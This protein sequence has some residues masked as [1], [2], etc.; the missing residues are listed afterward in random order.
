[1]QPPYGVEGPVIRRRRW[2]D[3]PPGRVR[4]PDSRRSNATS[5]EPKGGKGPMSAAEQ[6]VRVRAYQLWDQAGRPDD[7]SCEFW[8]AAKAELES[9]ERSGEPRHGVRHSADVRCE[10]AADWASDGRT[11]TSDQSRAPRLAAWMIGDPSNAPL[12]SHDKPGAVK[13]PVDRTDRFP[14]LRLPKAWRTAYLRFTSVPDSCVWPG[15]E[16]DA[17]GKAEGNAAF[18]P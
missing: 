15:V 17:D 3:S 10:T 1:M 11:R 16:R 14:V 13:G 7:R 6:A 5:H 4:R 2:R 9:K 12:A 8:L 18:R